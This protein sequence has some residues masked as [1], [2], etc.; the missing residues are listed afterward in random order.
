MKGIAI[1][2]FV[3]QETVEKKALAEVKAL[4]AGSK[5]TAG[6]MTIAYSPTPIPPPPYVGK[7]TIGFDEPTSGMML[8]LEGKIKSIFASFGTSITNVVYLSIVPPDPSGTPV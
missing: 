7:I 6:S 2:S 3:D 8:K 4:M 5:I 1:L